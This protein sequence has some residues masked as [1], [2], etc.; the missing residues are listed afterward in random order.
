[1]VLFYGNRRN[2]FERYLAIKSKKK[3]KPNLGKDLKVLHYLQ[4]SFPA[5][6]DQGV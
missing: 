5:C 3:D 2:N 1:M 4:K 6:F